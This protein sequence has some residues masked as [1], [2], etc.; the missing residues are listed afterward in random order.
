MEF[1]RRGNIRWISN[2][3]TNLVGYLDWLDHTYNIIKV[4]EGESALYCLDQGLK[5]SHVW[6]SSVLEKDPFLSTFFR[7][8]EEFFQGSSHYQLGDS[9]EAVFFSTGFF[10]NLIPPEC[11]VPTQDEAKSLLK[12]VKNLETAQLLNLAD[13]EGNDIYDSIDSNHRFWV[14]YRKGSYVRHYTPVTNNAIERI[15]VLY[16]STEYDNN[17]SYNIETKTSFFR[18][19]SGAL[20]QVGDWDYPDS[21]DRKR[22]WFRYAPMDF[23]GGHLGAPDNIIYPGGIYLGD[24]DE[25]SLEEHLAEFEQWIIDNPAGTDFWNPGTYWQFTRRAVTV[26]SMLLR[27]YLNYTRVLTD[28]Y[29]VGFLK[30]IKSFAMAVDPVYL[31]RILSAYIPGASLEPKSVV[32]WLINLIRRIGNTPPAQITPRVIDTPNWVYWSAAIIRTLLAGWQYQKARWAEF[33]LLV[34]PP[35]DIP[36]TG[37][38]VTEHPDPIFFSSGY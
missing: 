11:R 23:V 3:T 27:G 33:R 31:F 7:P 26:S 38:P 30:F 12:E 9:F 6:D 28:W 34:P 22:S 14:K 13:S 35:P 16:A 4:G 29:H 17:L 32:V 15:R 2:P 18:F 1:I 20:F 25:I 19:T 24:S 37:D 8:R 36:P 21:P 5:L 10:N